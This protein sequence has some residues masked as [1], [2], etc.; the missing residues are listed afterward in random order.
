V[1]LDDGADAS[2]QTGSPYEVGRLTPLI[3][4]V[5]NVFAAPGG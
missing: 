2:W 3:C 1:S 4:R 5:G